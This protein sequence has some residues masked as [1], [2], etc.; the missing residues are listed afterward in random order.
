MIAQIVGTITEAPGDA[1]ARAGDAP[2]RANA[3]Q[4]AGLIERLAT[5]QPFTTFVFWPEDQNVDQVTRF[6]TDVA[7]RFD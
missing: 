2:V 4:W 7:A 3:D 6:A 1:S 5:E